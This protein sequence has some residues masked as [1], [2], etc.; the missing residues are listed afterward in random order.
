MK[1]N[2][3]LPACDPSLLTGPEMA[4]VMSAFQQRRNRLNQGTPGPALT[5]AASV[6]RGAKRVIG[7]LKFRCA[8]K[9]ASRTL[10]P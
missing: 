10:I 1:A 3:G 5:L 8:E 7:G 4:S 6:G 9:P 2:S